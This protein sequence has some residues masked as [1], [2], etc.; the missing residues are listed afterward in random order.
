MDDD[1]QPAASEDER[2]DLG[3]DDLDVE[4]EDAERVIGG[5]KR[6]NITPCV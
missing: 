6:N 5:T 2:E 4:P 3:V 1:R